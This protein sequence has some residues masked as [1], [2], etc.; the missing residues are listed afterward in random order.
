MTSGPFQF[1]RIQSRS[2]QVRVG[3]KFFVTQGQNSITPLASGM[4]GARLPNLCGPPMAITSQAQPGWVMPSQA[5]CSGTNGDCA[6]NRP[7]RTSR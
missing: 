6:P 7:D 1:S 3:S 5:R 2:F 4:A